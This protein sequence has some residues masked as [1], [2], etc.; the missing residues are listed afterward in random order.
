MLYTARLEM[1][2]ITLEIVEAAM[3]GERSR[4]E[5]LA[6]ARVPEAW[7]G[8]ALIER[9]FS[10]SLEDIR[11]DP[12]SRLW[13]DRLLIAR[14]DE[15]RVVGSVVFHGRPGEDGVCEIGYGVEGSSQ[16][17]GYATEA[18]GAAVQWA[19]EQPEVRVIQAT[20]FGWHFASLR[21]LEKVGFARW[22]TRDHEI[23][24]ELLVYELAPRLAQITT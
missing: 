22:G 4:V 1:R 7:Q 12:E 16:R 11:A 20:T 14:E 3:S 23:L 5:A 9:A 2:P 10:A 6:H 13:G 17:Q 18:V 24:G 8:R 19:L 15:P 21:V